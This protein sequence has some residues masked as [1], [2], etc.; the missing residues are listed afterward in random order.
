MISKVPKLADPPDGGS[1]R[2]ICKSS[3]CG[4]SNNTSLSQIVEIQ[5]VEAIVGVPVVAAVLTD[6]STEARYK[7]ALT[8]QMLAALNSV[9]YYYDNLS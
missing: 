3:F 6:K 1:S 7:T 5:L 4:E 9:W 2:N 8:E